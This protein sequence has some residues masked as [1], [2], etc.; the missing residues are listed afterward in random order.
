MPVDP[1][2][3]ENISDGLFTVTTDLTDYSPG[4][5]AIFTAWNVG[6]GGTAEFQVQHLDAGADG[7]LGTA[8]DVL[9]AG[10]DGVYGTT[11]D[12]YGP[13]PGDYASD[14]DSFFAIDGVGIEGLDGVLGSDDDLRDGAAAMTAYGKLQ[15]EEMSDIERTAIQRALL[16]YCELDSLAMV[17]I[18]EGWREMIYG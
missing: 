9:D 7:V 15:F 14:H 3:A 4:S 12:G 13:A 1:D 8:D 11:D 17:M 18:Y 16:R 5:T 6:V 2:S 10:A